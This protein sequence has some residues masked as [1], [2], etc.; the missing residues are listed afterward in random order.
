MPLSAPNLAL[1]TLRVSVHVPVC[2][3]KVDQQGGPAKVHD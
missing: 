2:V 3:R 1:T